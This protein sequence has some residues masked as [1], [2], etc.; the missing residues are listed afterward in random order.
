MDWIFWSELHLKHATKIYTIIFFPRMTISTTM[1]GD[2]TSDE[3]PTL[4][5]RNVGLALQL[6]LALFAHRTKRISASQG[7]DL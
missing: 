3:I 7:I 6:N 5:E 2:P 1:Q 4:I